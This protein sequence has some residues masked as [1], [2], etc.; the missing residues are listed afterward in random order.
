MGIVVNLH[1]R[2]VICLNC[3]RAVDTKNLVEHIRKDLPFIEV[4]DDLPA[5]LEA[6]YKLVP[7]SSIVY[8]PGPIPPVFG[9]PL[10]SNPFFFCKC[11]KG[12]ST[13]EGMRSHQTRV[14]EHACAQKSKKPRYHKGYG[15]RLTSNRSIFE[16]NAIDWLLTCN[17]NLDRY[18]LVFTQSIP[19]LRDYS[20]MEILGAEDEMNTSS[21]FY[22]QRW[23]SH[24]KGYTAEDIQEATLGSTPEA[25]YGDRLKHVAEEFLSQANAEIQKHSSFGILK[26]MGQ[27]TE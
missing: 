5:V 20:K 27:T 18:P 24:L 3:E 4:P 23:L 2:C 8:K 14:G 9:I 26:L 15:Q 13:Y 19:P 6:T 12:Y 16:V 22:T 10:Q 7:Y 1:F 21:F 11:G 25:P 17:N